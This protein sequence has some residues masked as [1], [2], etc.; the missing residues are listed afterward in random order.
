MTLGTQMPCS[1]E[2]EASVLGAMML[3]NA[4]IERVAAKLTAG[5]FYTHDYASIFVAATELAQRGTP[6]DVTTLGDALAR[7][8]KLDLVG[9][10]ETLGA[11][12][13]NVPTAA[14]IDH[15]VALVADYAQRRRV[16]TAADQL[17]ARAMGHGGES[18]GE[19]LAAAREQFAEV[20]A[21]PHKV[22]WSYPIAITADELAG[23][24]MAPTCIVENLLYADVALLVAPGGTG[25]TTAV[26][27]EAVHIA[28][29]RP[30]YGL[31]VLHPGPVLIV[32]AEDS[33]ETCVARL[34]SICEA[35]LLSPYDLA[36]VLRD[37]RISDVRGAGF[38]LTRI[39]GD[40]VVPALAIN[41]MICECQRRGVVLINIDPTV[42]FGVGESRVNDA[43]Q[44]LI[45]AARRLVRELGCCVRFIHHVAKTVARERIIDQYAARGGTALPDGARMVTVMLPMSEDEW[46]E[47]TMVS[48]SDGES[49]VRMV[50]PK[51]S[52]AAP[53]PDILLAR[54]GFT[55]V[56]SSPMERDPTGMLNTYC[57]QVVR[58]VHT[59][60][61]AGHFPSKNSIEAAK[62]MPRTFLRDA[63]ATLLARGRIEY[64]KVN[65]AQ[66]GA[67]QYLRPVASPG[68][69]GEPRL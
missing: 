48:L 56:H 40:V 50:R 30:L 45:D 11:L 17:R 63:L 37:V 10:I 43:E 8:G 69:T 29:G 28:L 49:A 38:K 32:T 67:R 31:R 66:R 19:I 7:V 68:S 33:R 41:R 22:A 54:K 44:G 21:G 12:V 14:N 3:D 2:A 20:E 16:A 58:F 6:V 18:V 34:R 27:Y 1:A 24:R 25:K 39:E 55:F 26:L 53:Q 15:Y 36:V 5:D 9:G 4:V 59:E 35:L 61:E 23:A 47:A 65:G 51:L 64:V 13:Q 60:I 52:Y 46:R 42:S 57:E 62:I